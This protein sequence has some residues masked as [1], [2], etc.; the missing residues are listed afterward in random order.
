VELEEQVSQ[1]VVATVREGRA[2]L[3]VFVAGPDVRGLDVRDFR[4]D[5]LVLILPRATGL[6]AAAPWPSSTR[7]TSIGSA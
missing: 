5:E 4:N 3:G 7:W 1:Q 6:P 2:D